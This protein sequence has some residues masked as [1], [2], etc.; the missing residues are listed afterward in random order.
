[1]GDVESVRAARA[2]RVVVVTA[3]ILDV[4]REAGIHVDAVVGSEADPAEAWEDGMLATPPGLVA[5]TRGAAGG[6]WWTADTRESWDPA[7]LPG[8]AQDA[9][10]CGDSFAAGLTY[11]LATGLGPRE[12]IALAARSGA[13]AVTRR[14]AHG[15]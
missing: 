8:P 5:R 2:A 7:P 4:V 15:G 13:L 10:G 12:A 3:R 11:G 6:T 9:Y 1:K 14:G